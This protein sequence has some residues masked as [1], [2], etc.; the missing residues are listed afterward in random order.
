MSNSNLRCRTTTWPRTSRCRRRHSCARWQARCGRRSWIS[1]SSGPRPSV[2][3]RPQWAARRA[4]WPT[5]STSSW[6]PGCSGWCAPGGCG[7]STSG[8][9]AARPASSAWA[10]STWPPHPFGC[11]RQPTVRGCRRSRPRARRRRAPRH[12]SPRPDPPEARRQFWEH[13]LAL[14]QEFAKL[15]RSGDT[16]YGFAAGL[17]PTDH[18]TLPD[19]LATKP[20]RLVGTGL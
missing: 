4:P 12:P 9:T 7:R 19:R 11:R 8:T 17:Y 15:P 14:A 13:V 2:S 5:T 16:V 1:C 10:R 3:S 20:S 6:T 18:P